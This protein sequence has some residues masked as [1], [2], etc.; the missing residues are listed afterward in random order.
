MGESRKARKAEQEMAGGGD[1]LPASGAKAIQRVRRRNSF[2]LVLQRGHKGQ[3]RRCSDIEDDLDV[4][5][6]VI[7]QYLAR[8]RAMVAR[9]SCLGTDRPD[10]QYAA[11]EA[12]G[13]M[14]SSRRGREKGARIATFKRRA[15]S[16]RAVV[17]IRKG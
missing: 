2:V 9:C 3:T 1:G 14:A 13:C 5:E 16:A 11:T 10:L 17:P 6:R 4:G 7:S 12:S 8:C 15:S